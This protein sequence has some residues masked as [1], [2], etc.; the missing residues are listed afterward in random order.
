MTEQGLRLAQKSQGVAA[1]TPYQVPDADPG[2][3]MFLIDNKPCNEPATFA[4]R[5]PAGASSGVFLYCNEHADQ[6]ERAMKRR[7]KTITLSRV[8]AGLAVFCFAAVAAPL[9]NLPM[10]PAA[11]PA[12][13]LVGRTNIFSLTLTWT[14][15]ASSNVVGYNVYEG[16]ASE[17]YTNEIFVGDVT[18]VTVPNLVRG[19]RYFFAAA[20]VEADGRRSPLSEEMSFSGWQD[21]AWL[22]LGQSTDLVSWSNSPICQAT[23]GREF[24]RLGWQTRRVAV[25]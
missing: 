10:P 5:T 12:P 25:P 1:A 18:N 17:V 6:I 22:V 11:T 21:Q 20:S 4:R 8:A 23:N 2:G 16:T 7:G 13:A 15:S 9:A 14:P 24:Y 19:V 3:C